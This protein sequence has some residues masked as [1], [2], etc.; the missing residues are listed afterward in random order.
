[1]F[2]ISSRSK[3]MI[4][5]LCGST[6]IS[7]TG[8][9]IRNMEI[10]GALEINLFRGISLGLTILLILGIK[11]KRQTFTKIVA[12]GKPG[13]SAA[14][15]LA[16]AG[17][18]FLQA[19]TN[20]TVAETLFI[21]S[22]IPIL[23]AALAWFFLN[24]RLN[25]VTLSA[26]CC[27]A[28]GIS[29]MFMGD[30]GSRSHYGASMALMTASLFSSYTII[31]RKYRYIEMLPALG[32]SGF[33]ITIFCLLTL[34]TNLNFTMFDL[35]RCILLGSLISLIPSMIFLYSSK[36]LFAGELTLFMLLEFSLGP[37]WVW[38]FINEAP[39]FWTLVG[40][41]LI[42]TALTLRVWAEMKFTQTDQPKK[43]ITS[44]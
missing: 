25:K 20:T 2:P 38:I 39:E 44:N 27:A 12:I 35:Y 17:I 34:G 22:C 10:A 4:F 28:I 16:A 13:L 40:G 42:M 9:I 5:M 6:L 8:L 19:I 29:L 41:A 21:T 36:Y 15:A 33:L 1:M 18:C 23:T 32:L 31:I 37:L 14:F 7:S 11:H 30:F 24:E 26:I 3:A 43:N